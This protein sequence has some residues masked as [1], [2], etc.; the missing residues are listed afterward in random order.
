[1]MKHCVVGPGS[2]TEIAELQIFQLI[3]KIIGLIKSGSINNATK[4]LM[5]SGMERG[6]DYPFLYLDRILWVFM[7]VT[8]YC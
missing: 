6:L 8:F 7:S 4:I 2:H 1:M 5:N 3:H